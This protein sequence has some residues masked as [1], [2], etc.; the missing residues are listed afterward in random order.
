MRRS[1]SYS[2]KR[3]GHLYVRLVSARGV[4]G[5]KGTRLNSYV[6][7]EC[8]GQVSI[9]STV[10]RTSNP[11]WNEFFKF[12]VRDY[13]RSILTIRLV[14]AKNE[15][16]IAKMRIPVR[17]FVEKAAKKQNYEMGEDVS[18]TVDIGYENGRPKG[19][20][21]LHPMGTQMLKKSLIQI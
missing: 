21:S 16:S 20:D 6:E 18:M 19:R 2:S 12:Y 13:D 8:N 15:L 9:S 17:E 10:K 7:L 4:F 1:R 14:D 11:E 3:S 5:A